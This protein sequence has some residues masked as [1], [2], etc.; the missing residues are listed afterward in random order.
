M[1]KTYTTQELIDVILKAVEGGYDFCQMDSKKKPKK[2][3]SHTFD[4]TNMMVEL[5]YKDGSRA[6]R[7]INPVAIQQEGGLDFLYSKEFM[8]ATYKKT[9]F[10]DETKELKKQLDPVKFLANFHAQKAV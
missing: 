9:K 4:A 10:A 8:K 1:E 7:R 2:V 3:E 6:R 5:I